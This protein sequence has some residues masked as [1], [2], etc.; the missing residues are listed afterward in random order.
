[1]IIGASIISTIKVSGITIIIFT[2]GV[3]Q[4]AEKNFVDASISFSLGRGSLINT[5]KI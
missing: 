2:L 5:T 4:Q 1:M 3:N